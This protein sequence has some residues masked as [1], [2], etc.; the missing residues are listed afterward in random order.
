MI[1]DEHDLHILQK[2][3][4]YL[5]SIEY[6]Q[7][8]DNGVWEE[9]EEIHASSVGACVAGLSAVSHLVDVP[10]D[11]I[12]N[13]R[14]VLNNLLPRE[15]ETK[16]VDLALLTLIFPYDVVSAEQRDAILENVEKH[17]V[18]DMGVIRYLG[19]QYYNKGS[20]AEWTFGFPWLARIYLDLGNQKK[21]GHYLKKTLSCMTLKGDLPEL[22]FGNSHK[23][24][25][26]SPLGWAQAMYLCATVM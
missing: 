23:H 3:V 7:D 10:E 1:R 18:R 20:E 16:E 12:Q 14:D 26:N 22:Y 19:D 21:Y 2:L 15:S 8:Q 24:N 5:A 9:N 11:L 25:E 13:G 6:W 17:L 4:N